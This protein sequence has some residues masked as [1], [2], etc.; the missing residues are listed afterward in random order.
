[1]AGAVTATVMVQF[2]N[3]GSGI[4]TAE[5]DTRP[6][7]YNNGRSTFSAGDEPVILVRKTP[8][9]SMQ[10]ITSAGSCSQFGTGTTEELEFLTYMRT[11]TASASKPISS[12][13]SSN[14][15]GQSLGVVRVSGNKDVVIDTTEPITGCGVLGITY[16]SDFIAYK[17]SGVP[18]MLNGRSDFSVL[19]GFIGTYDS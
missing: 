17:L 11:K 16:N 4:L 1:M 14:W 15:Y 2:T 13:F 9:V 18:A 5:L 8:N 3:Q 7:G 19:V 10:I 6:E 12:G